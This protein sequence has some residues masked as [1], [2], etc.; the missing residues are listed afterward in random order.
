MDEHLVEGWRTFYKWWS[1][2]GLAA[3]AS[4]PVAYENFPMLQSALPP[5]VFRY[6]MTALA[7]LTF[8]AR[9]KKQP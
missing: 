1:T 5:T 9:M 6:G 8:I 7:V 3:L 2:W 4:A